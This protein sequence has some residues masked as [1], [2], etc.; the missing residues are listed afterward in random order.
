MARR[1]EPEHVCHALP[2]LRY[3]GTN[4]LCVPSY[5]DSCRPLPIPSG[6][7]AV[8]RSQ[9]SRYRSI[10]NSIDTLIA[11]LEHMRRHMSLMHAKLVQGWLNVGSMR[12]DYD[13]GRR[14]P[15]R[16]VIPLLPIFPAVPLFS[17]YRSH[18]RPRLIA[19]PEAYGDTDSSSSAVEFEGHSSGELEEIWEMV[20]IQLGEVSSGPLYYPY[21]PMLSRGLL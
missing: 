20:D 3:D 15:F 2:T 1:L 5:C 16:T 7:W 13:N 10:I 12:R 4:M 14:T 21:L 18:P 17:P 11:V 19:S 8:S 6:T 9:R